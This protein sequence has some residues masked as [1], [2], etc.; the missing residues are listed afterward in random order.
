MCA[1]EVFLKLLFTYY[2]IIFNLNKF[3]VVKEIT[4]KYFLNTVSF[5]IHH[6]F[7][8][9]GSGTCYWNSRNDC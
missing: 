6:N 9:L 5:R 4:K 1:L 8:S 7:P 2:F 3:F